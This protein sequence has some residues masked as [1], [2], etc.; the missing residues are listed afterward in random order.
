VADT[1]KQTTTPPLSVPLASGTLYYLL[2][3]FNHKKHEHVVW[4]GN[5][6]NLGVDAIVFKKCD[7]VFNRSAWSGHLPIEDPSTE[8]PPLI[9]GRL[10]S[11]ITKLP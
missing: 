9:D 1:A 6:P 4:K 11:L 5:T 3:D 8:S 2:D 7:T 10:H